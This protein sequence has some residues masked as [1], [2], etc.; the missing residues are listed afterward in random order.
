MIF[1]FLKVPAVS[2]HA[3]I[4]TRILSVCGIELQ[5]NS[6]DNSGRGLKIPALFSFGMKYS[7]QY[8]LS[9]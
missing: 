3:F 7:M 8:T 2:G 4:T 1:L 6:N 9:I 5:V